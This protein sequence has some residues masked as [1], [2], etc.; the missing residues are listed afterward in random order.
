M[1]NLKK[2]WELKYDFVGVRLKNNNPTLD[3]IFRFKKGFGGDLKQGYLWKLDLLPMKAK[4]Y[5]VI[6]KMMKGEN[7]VT[8]IIDQVSQ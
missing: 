7:R 5:D 3:G 4:A 1:K 2:H 8:D 6:V